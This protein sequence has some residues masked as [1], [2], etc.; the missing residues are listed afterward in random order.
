M[1]KDDTSPM[2]DINLMEYFY[3]PEY[4]QN[5]NVINAW[6]IY[7]FK[8]LPLVSKKWKDAISP[9]KLT[10]ET[11]MFSFITIS[12]E[13]LMRWFLKLWIPK[14][15]CENKEVAVNDSGKEVAVSDS[16][17]EIN[18]TELNATISKKRGPHDSN[19]KLNIYTALFHEIAIARK[20]YSTAVRWNLL[21]WD[22]V[23]KRTDMLLDKP[24]DSTKGKKS[25]TNS[26]ELPL[27]D[28]NENQEFLASY[29][30]DS[31]KEMDEDQHDDN[32]SSFGVRSTKQVSI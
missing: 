2:F 1:I 31:N 19:V 25:L 29:N 3:N 23:K 9:D 30:I 21:F 20:N 10:R 24:V 27:P 4:E 16:G 14:L 28:L 8:I 18:L 7:V 32:D 11:S 22:E 13:A 5:E 12:D 6:Y 15:L 26:M 17:K